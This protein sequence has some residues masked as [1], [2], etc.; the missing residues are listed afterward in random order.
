[1]HLVFFSILA[2]EGRIERGNQGDVKE[3]YD[4]K[5]LT[6]KSMFYTHL[7]CFIMQ[8]IFEYGGI[9]FFAL[10]FCSGYFSQE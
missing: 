5:E 8:I 4:Y 7:I 10:C 9:T 2:K 3:F 6:V 1:M